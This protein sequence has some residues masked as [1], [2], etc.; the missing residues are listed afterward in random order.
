MSMTKREVDSFLKGKWIARLATLRKDGSPHLTP[1]WYDWDGRKFVIVTRTDRVKYRN[2]AADS[3]VAISVD[4]NEMPYKGVI[5][6]GR[7]EIMDH[8]LVDNMKRV[9]WKY[10]DKPDERERYLQRWLN[11]PRSLVLVHP[12]KMIMWDNSKRR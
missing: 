1:V 3:R 9:I 10:A 11:E 7:A 12:T 2:V 6:E 4:N 5:A 8:N